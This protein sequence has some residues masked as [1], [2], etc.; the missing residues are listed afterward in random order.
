MHADVDGACV[1]SYLFIDVQSVSSSSRL[2]MKAGDLVELLDSDAAGAASSE[3]STSAAGA[4]GGA[5]SRDVDL[6]YGRNESTGKRGSFTA[7]CV[8]VLPTVDKPTPDF[9]VS[10]SILANVRIAGIPRRRHRH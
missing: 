6:L 3:P 1:L 2:A 5:R 8:Y 7:S 10:S 9:I 4:S